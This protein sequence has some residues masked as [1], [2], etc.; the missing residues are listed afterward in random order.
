MSQNFYSRGKLLITGEYFV[1]NGSLAFAVPLKLGQ[2]MSVQYLDDNRGELSWETKCEKK[3]WFWAKYELGKIKLID[4]SHQSQAKFIQQIFLQIQQLSKVISMGKSSIKISTNIEFPVNW[5]LGSSSSLIS[6]LADWAKV[7]PYQL[8][9][10]V[11]NGSGFD[12]A[13][14]RSNGPLLYQLKD[15]PQ[16][17][18][19]Q[20]DKNFLD[21]IFFIYSGKKQSTQT[22]I[23]K[24]A[25]FIQGLTK[26]KDR[27]SDLTGS[28]ATSGT[29]DEFESYI[30]EHEDIISHAIGIPS[31]KTHYF[32]D[33]EG[34][35]KSLGAWGGDF[36]M[37]SH[38]DTNYLQNYFKQKGYRTIFPYKKLV[39]HG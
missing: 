17:E 12:I 18:E 38:A 1:L 31:L 13:C 32:N 8:L 33:F 39:Y 24:Y 14:A 9:W 3:T 11:M 23:R 10:K 30:R 4:T 37:A 22:S 19:I 21:S 6:N 27:I 25:S 7:N 35:V 20:F 29:L 15:K 34:G 36:F 28:V 2:N 16:V 5:G 26:E